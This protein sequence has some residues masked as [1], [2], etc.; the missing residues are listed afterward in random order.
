MQ[1]GKEQEKQS[2]E[3][4]KPDPYRSV[5]TQWSMQTTINLQKLWCGY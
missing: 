4:E 3:S 5:V 1:Q 2:K